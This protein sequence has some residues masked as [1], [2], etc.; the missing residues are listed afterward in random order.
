M[1]LIIQVPCFNEEDQLPGMLAELPR[2]LPG[3]DVVEWL[4]VDDGS[5][6]A[7]VETARRCGVD[8]I[9]RLPNHK[10]LAAAFQ[11][12]L[13]ACLKLG[14]DVIVNSDADNQYQAADIPLLVGP[15]LAGEADLVIGSRELETIAHFSPAKRRLQ[16]LGSAVVRSASET[17]VPD[18]TSGFRA[19][20]REAAL[21]V[22]VVSK[23]TYTLE[24]IIQ[25][26]KMLIAVAHVGV[27]TNPP[28]RESRLLPSTSAYVRKNMLAIARIYTMYEPLRVFLA[29]AALA[30]LVGCVVWVRF[31]YYFA[32]GDGRGHVQSVILGGTMLVIAVQFAGLAIVADVLAAIRL[33]LQR[34]LER[35]QRL[36]AACRHRALALPAGRGGSPAR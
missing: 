9:V 33:L 26:G 8:H 22:Q 17:D 12:G 13:D 14:A 10:G 36:R 3:I 2:T 27:R 23:Y 34:T 1:K 31:L 25:A 28:V 20:N 4:V 11:A 35:V 24:T 5:S 15:I 18:A 7:T 29:A 21:Q 32:T 6:D 19:Y 30:G 16:R